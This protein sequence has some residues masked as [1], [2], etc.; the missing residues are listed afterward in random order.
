MSGSAAHS[1]CYYKLCP[2]PPPTG[3]PECEAAAVA[4]QLQREVPG[5][6]LAIISCDRQA[7]HYQLLV[8]IY[9]I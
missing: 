7:I 2:A 1:T 9:F 3:A 4:M 6:D 5:R 8:Y